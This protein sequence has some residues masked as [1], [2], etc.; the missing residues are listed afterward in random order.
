[1]EFKQKM[2][3]F[4]YD[5]FVLFHNHVKTDAYNGMQLCSMVDGRLSNL[6][7]RLLFILKI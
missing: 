3:L 2:S 4:V 1:M 7:Y 5:A 6:K